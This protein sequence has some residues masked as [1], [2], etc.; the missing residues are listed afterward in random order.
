MKK[1]P[2][3]FWGLLCLLV[4]AVIGVIGPKP[5]NRPEMLGQATGQLEWH[6]L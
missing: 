5:K 3:W 4:G 2:L 6:L 1:Q